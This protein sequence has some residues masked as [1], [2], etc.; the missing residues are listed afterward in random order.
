MPKS[1]Q[2]LKINLSLI[3]LC[4]GTEERRFW[5][6]LSHHEWL[7]PSDQFTSIFSQMPDELTPFHAAIRASS[8]PDPAI[9]RA[10]SRLN[11]KAS[12][13]VTRRLSINS[14]RVA[15]LTIYPRY[16]LNP[17]D[18]PIAVLFYHRSIVILHTVSLYRVGNHRTVEAFDIPLPLTFTFYLPEDIIRRD[19]HPVVI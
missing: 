2:I 10:S 4:R 19:R 14:S 11:S 7:P 8:K 18:P 16:F 5:F 9:R 12:F 17:A 1:L 15:L 3:S 6:G 13:K